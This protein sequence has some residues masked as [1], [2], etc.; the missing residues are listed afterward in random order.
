MILSI[1]LPSPLP[2]SPRPLLPFSHPPP[3]PLFLFLFF[4]LVILNGWWGGG[5]GKRGER[6]EWFWSFVSERQGK[7]EGGRMRRKKMMIRKKKEK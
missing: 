1:I 2:F 7:G 4:S 3:S 5:G 6:G